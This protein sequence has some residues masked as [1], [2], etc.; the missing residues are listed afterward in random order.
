MGR[1]AIRTRPPSHSP[2]AA[3]FLFDTIPL[4]ESSHEA[5]GSCREIPC[6]DFQK[7]T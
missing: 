2:A 7:S 3:G 6:M 4:P 5:T 1:A